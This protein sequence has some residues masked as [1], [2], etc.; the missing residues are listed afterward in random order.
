MNTDIIFSYSTEA[1]NS[2]VGHKKNRK[3]CQEKL[4]HFCHDIRKA[5]KEIEQGR[6]KTGGGKKRTHIQREQDEELRQ[7][8]YIYMGTTQTEGKYGISP[9][10]RITL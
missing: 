7:L 1:V 10:Y 4:K 5:D 2:V 6:K 3:Q 9:I 8:A